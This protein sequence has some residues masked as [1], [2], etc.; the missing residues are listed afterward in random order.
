MVKSIKI[1]LFGVKISPT[2]IYPIPPSPTNIWQ[3][4]HLWSQTKVLH[5]LNDDI[6]L[7]IQFHYSL[8]LWSEFVQ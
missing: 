2:H 5:S 6:F 7:V 4:I 8:V 1:S 3:N